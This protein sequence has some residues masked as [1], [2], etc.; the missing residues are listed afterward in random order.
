MI[1]ED[2]KLKNN[3]YYIV[4]NIILSF[5]CPSILINTSRKDAINDKLM[6]LSE[7][8]TLIIIAIIL[9]GKKYSIIINFITSVF[10]VLNRNIEQF[11]YF[12]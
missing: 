9:L 1:K 6:H 8:F 3:K 7:N 5:L 11:L 4:T 12:F 10:I 2:F